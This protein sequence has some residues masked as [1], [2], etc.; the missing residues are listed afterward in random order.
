MMDRLEAGTLILATCITGG[1]IVLPDAPWRSM[2]SFLYFLDQMGHSVEYDTNSPAG[3]SLTA[4]TRPRAISLK[5]MPYP[6]FPTDLQAQTMAVL[7]LADGVSMIEETV[8]ENR[9]L[10][11]R[12]LNNM[13]AQITLQGTVATVTGVDHLYGSPVIASDIRAAAGLV[14]A[15]LAAQ[16]V[17]VLTGVHHMYRGY[18]SLVGQLQS[19]GAHIEAGVLQ[20][21][22]RSAESV[23]L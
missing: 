11:V 5:T 2:E 18:E 6:G 9:M 14:I 3:L 4:C 15:G 12:E 22:I 13:G 21:T 19:M 8:F 23:V 10:H 20:P 16:G 17:T 7:A 1:S